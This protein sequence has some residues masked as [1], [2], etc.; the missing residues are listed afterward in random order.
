MGNLFFE[1]FAKEGNFTSFIATLNSGKEVE[2]TLVHKIFDYLDDK[3]IVVEYQGN[4]K[5]NYFMRFKDISMI[6]IK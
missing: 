3:W 1:K 2:F 6:Q 5:R 4:E